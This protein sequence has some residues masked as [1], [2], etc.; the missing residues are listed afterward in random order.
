M[1]VMGKIV[2]VNRCKPIGRELKNRFKT[3]R[4]KVKATS[5][6]CQCATCGTTKKTLRDLMYMVSRVIRDLI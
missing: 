6:Q 2:Y 1:C 5:G 4:V 3:W